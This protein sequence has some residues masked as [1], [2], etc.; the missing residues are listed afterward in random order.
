MKA[1]SVRLPWSLFIA[2][3]EKSVEYRTWKTSYRGDVL[4]CTSKYK[5]AGTFKNKILGHSVCLAKIV[6][7]VPFSEEFLDQACM[8]EMPDEYGYALILEDIR[9]VKPEPVKGKLMIF[10]TDYHPDFLPYEKE[11]LFNYYVE[12][13]WIGA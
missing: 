7:C 8:E 9:P 13:E 4:I 10:E 11:D 12:N 1:L 2:T 3:G 6:D 5:E